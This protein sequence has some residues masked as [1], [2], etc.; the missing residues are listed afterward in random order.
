MSTP[1]ISV[2]S[3]RKNSDSHRHA[4]VEGIENKSNNLIRPQSTLLTLE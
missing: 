2:I 4:A 3:N 1:I